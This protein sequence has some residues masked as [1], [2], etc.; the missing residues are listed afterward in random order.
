MKRSAAALD[1]ALVC[2]AIVLAWAITRIV[3]YP[4]LGIPDYYPAILRP[5]LGFLTAWVLLRR[6]GER[7]TNFG[8]RTPTRWGIAIVGAVALYL[9]NLALVMWVVPAI[10]AMFK[11]DAQPSFLAYIRG[12]AAAFALWL[13]IGWIVGGFIEECLFRGFL[14]TRVSQLFRNPAIGLPV[15]VIAQAVLFGMLHLYGGVFAFLFTAVFAVANGIF[16]LLFGRNLWPLIAVHG[17][18]NSVQIWSVYSS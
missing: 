6:R 17:A 8:L 10:A 1:I 12:N 14:L 9:V 7:W 18:W 5:I 15:A 11:P 3:L 4:A 16:Y 13:S 2:A